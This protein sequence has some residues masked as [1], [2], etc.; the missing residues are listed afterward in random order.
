V[1][2]VEVVEVE[3]EEVE[4]AVEVASDGTTAAADGTTAAS[5]PGLPIQERV[6][7]GALLLSVDEEDVRHRPPSYV[8]QLL[9]S[10]TSLQSNSLLFKLHVVQ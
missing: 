10:R 7:V 3:V 5:L 8:Y 1:E 6:P 2:E 9:Q 4:A